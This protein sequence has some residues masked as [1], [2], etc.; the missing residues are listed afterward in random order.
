MNSIF[1]HCV[2]ILLLALLF[3]TSPTA[4]AKGNEDNPTVVLIDESGNDVDVKIDPTANDVDAIVSNEV[5]VKNDSGSALLVDH[6]AM[7]RIPFA[8]RL[9]DGIH[10]QSISQSFTV[11]AGHIVVIETISTD[12]IATG[13]GPRSARVSVMT[14]DVSVSAFLPLHT[15]PGLS[16]EGDPRYVALQLVRLY[17]DPDSSINF[18]ASAESG[19]SIIGTV[20]IS[21]YLIPDD[22]P[23]L[24]P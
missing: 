17:A 21:G 8:I 20:G 6:G 14:N 3:G 22:E 2:T 4:F 13:N 9:A 12:L 24:A 1:R 16:L 11:P 19:E 23:S 18:F 15:Q 7:A 10:G 5:E